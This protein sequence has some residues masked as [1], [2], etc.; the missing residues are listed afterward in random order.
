VAITAAPWRSRRA[1]PDRASRRVARS[2]WKAGAAATS[3]AFMD[4]VVLVSVV[5]FLM[6]IAGVGVLVLQ[7]TGLTWPT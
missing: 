7:Q 4:V 5:L 6:L 3:D 2:S 1:A